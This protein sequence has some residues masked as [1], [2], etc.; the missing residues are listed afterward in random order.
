MPSMG[1]RVE[2]E[3]RAVRNQPWIPV[4]LSLVGLSALLNGLGALPAWHGVV[5]VVGGAVLLSLA[6][7]A[8]YLKRSR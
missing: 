1:E 7:W 6:V 3:R 4:V 8:L 2:R 5:R